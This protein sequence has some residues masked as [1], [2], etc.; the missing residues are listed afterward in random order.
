[1][2]FLRRAWK[3]ISLREL[4][5]GMRERKVPRRGVLV[6]FDDGYADN[7]HNAKPILERYEIPAVVFVAGGYV[8]SEREYWWDE[9]EN[10]LLLPGALPEHLQ[11]HL[12]GVDISW[13]LGETA[14]FYSEQNYRDHAGWNISKDAPTE[15]HALYWKL[16]KIIRPLPAPHQRRVLEE[17]RVWSNGKSA[18][19]ESHRPMAPKELR[20][21]RDGNLI[22]IGAHTISHPVLSSLPLDVQRE[23]IGGSRK[24]LEE[25][26]GRPISSFAYPYGGDA[27]YTH[28][29]VAAVRE[30]GFESAFSTSSGVVQKDSESFRLPRNWVRDWKL[31]AFAARLDQWFS[32]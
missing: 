1:M 26:V 9:L 10:L 6:T 17:L 24:F 28:E 15:R 16:Y 4:S 14:R 2:Q 22:E 21:L 23:E 32:V 3:P 27:D 31:D 13:R 12:N 30:A 18:A 29:T 8:G 19:R 5:V 20:T 7:L 11:L 25:I